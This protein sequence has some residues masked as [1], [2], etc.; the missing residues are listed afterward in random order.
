L[1]HGNRTSDVSSFLVELIVGSSFISTLILQS[2]EMFVNNTI[3][4]G[5][6]SV[7]SASN[8]YL[9]ARTQEE[10]DCG[11]MVQTIQQW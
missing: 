4:H 5:I 9:F 10:G 8:Y 3:I 6:I 7:I 1:L 2:L 11:Y